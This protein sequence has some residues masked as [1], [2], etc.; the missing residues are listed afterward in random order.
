MQIE[1]IKNIYSSTATSRVNDVYTT[2]I[3]PKTH[4]HEYVHTVYTYQVYDRKGKLH[5]E[6][7]SKHVDLQA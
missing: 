4:K 7:I 6:Q 2:W 1:Q 3:D 5:E